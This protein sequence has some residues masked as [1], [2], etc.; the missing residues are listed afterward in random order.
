ML[1]FSRAGRARSNLAVR[2]LHRLRYNPGPMRTPNT[3]RASVLIA[4]ALILPACATVAADLP[5]GQHVGESIG[6]RPIHAFA[7]LDASPTD[8]FDQTLLVQARV[9]AVCQSMGCWMQVED[10]GHTA[11][12]RWESGCGGKYAFPEAAVGQEVLIQGSFYP[13]VI[14]DADV[15]HLQGEAGEGVTI[16]KEGYEFNAS[17]IVILDR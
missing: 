14:S 8:F 12:V 2:Q 9:T 4:L 17:A 15:E 11:M 1:G 7:E 5:P 10:G 3:L 6:S 16:E 13:K